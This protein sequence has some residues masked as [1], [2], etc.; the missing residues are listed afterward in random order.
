MSLTLPE[1]MEHLKDIEETVFLEMFNISTDEL[2]ERF[3]DKIEDR[4]DE[5]MKEFGND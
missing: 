2:V 3:E 5:L 4:Y 1:L